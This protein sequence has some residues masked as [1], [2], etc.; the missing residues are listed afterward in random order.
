MTDDEANAFDGWH[1]HSNAGGDSHCCPHCHRSSQLSVT[2]PYDA[3]E[4]VKCPGCGEEFVAWI[5]EVPVGFSAKL[6]EL[7]EAD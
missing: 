7:A 1:E 6:P 5:A 2:A 4:V 3:P